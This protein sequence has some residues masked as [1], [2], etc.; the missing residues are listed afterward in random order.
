MKVFINGSFIPSI[1]V[2]HTKDNLNRSCL[3]FPVQNYFFI[4]YM[5]KWLLGAEVKVW[6]RPFHALKFVKIIMGSCAPVLK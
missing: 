6:S 4:N 5:K 1:S 3:T 2:K